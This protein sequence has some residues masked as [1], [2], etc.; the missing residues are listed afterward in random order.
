VPFNARAFFGRELRAAMDYLRYLEH[1]F[2]HAPKLLVR[3]ELNAPPFVLDAL[4]RPGANTRAGRRVLGRTLEVLDR[5]VPHHPDIE[6]FVR[7]C[8]ADLVLVTPLVEPGSP[9]SD[10]VRAAGALGVPVGL[11]VY[12]W[13]NLTNKGLIHDRLDLV[14]VWN[15]AMKEEAV[16]LHKVPPQRVEVTG[17]AAHDHWF[18]WRPRESR[19]QFCARVGLPADRPYLLYV[20]SSR[21]IAPKEAEFIRRWISELAPVSTLREVGARATASAEPDGMANRATLRSERVVVWPREGRIH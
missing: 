14:T 5:A 7:A 9:Q 16:T 13:D 4:T 8:A 18:D 17:A 12:S 19:E 3:A 15:N 20:C 10:Y 2:E 1:E 21:F 6:E 11:C